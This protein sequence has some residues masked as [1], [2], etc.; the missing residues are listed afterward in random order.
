MDDKS[1]VF[2]DS[3]YFEQDDSPLS[4]REVW[5]DDEVIDDEDA[6]PEDGTY[7]A[8]RIAPNSPPRLRIV[9]NDG[10]FNQARYNMMDDQ[11]FMGDRWLAFL[12]TH[13]VVVLEG[14]NLDM[15]ARPLQEEKVRWV[16]CFN[17]ERHHLPTDKTQPFILSIQRFTHEQYFAMMETLH[18]GDDEDTE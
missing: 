15:L 1:S 8:Y 13:Y 18:H 16:M 4:E 9:G 2:K 7:V 17:P 5:S 10:T 3:R 14:R 12:F 6:L 11:V